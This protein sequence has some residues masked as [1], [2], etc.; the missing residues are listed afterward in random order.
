M[1]LYVSIWSKEF[2]LGN[3]RQ[4]YLEKDY[5]INDFPININNIKKGNIVN[6]LPPNSFDIYKVSIENIDVIAGL[7]E[8]EVK[9]IDIKSINEI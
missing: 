4:G 8:I 3:G 1:D 9:V 7:I 6:Y 5:P 2:D